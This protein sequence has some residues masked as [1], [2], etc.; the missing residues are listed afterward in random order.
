[1]HGQQNIKFHCGNLTPFMPKSDKL[2]Q[3]HVAGNSAYPTHPLMSQIT[4]SSVKVLPFIKWGW[5]RQWFM[6]WD[7]PSFI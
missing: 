2:R 3:D 1:M 7:S 6:E 5:L 4:L